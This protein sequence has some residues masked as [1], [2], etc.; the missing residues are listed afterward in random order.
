MVSEKPEKIAVFLPPKGGRSSYG[1]MLTTAFSEL[2]FETRELMHPAIEQTIRNSPNNELTKDLLLETLKSKFHDFQPDV[3]IDL[4]PLPPEIHNYTQNHGTKTVFWLL[5]DGFKE[6]YHY[7]Q[8]M[9]EVSDLFISYQGEPFTPKNADYVPWGADPQLKSLKEIHRQELII[10][11]SF[12]ENRAKCADFI[13]AKFS[14]EIPI[15][16]VGPGWKQWQKFNHFK[17]DERIK[18]KDKWTRPTETA[19][20]LRGRIVVA[21][22]RVNR[23]NAVLP[24]YWFSVGAGGCL[25]CDRVKDF[26]RH[27]TEGEDCLMFSDKSE[28]KEHL[29]R[30]IQQPGETEKIQKQGRQKVLNH[31]TLTHRARTILEKLNISPVKKPEFL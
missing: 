9:A 4:N 30:L 10:H 22:W 21:P 7:W 18:I 1:P 20:L 5:E 3:L 27:V 12:S 13:C 23:H 2:G 19:R 8:K 29:E 26:S 17:Q 25:V 28:L 14:G 15:N 31:H 24:R 6:E 11:G 16:I